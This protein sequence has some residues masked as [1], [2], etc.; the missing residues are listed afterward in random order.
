MI[1]Y[2]QSGLMSKCTAENIDQQSKC[3][4][5]RK[6]T[7]YNRCRFL[8]EAIGNHCDC[9]AAQ[10]YAKNPQE[11]TEEEVLDIEAYI[12][13]PETQRTYERSCLDCQKADKSCPLPAGVGLLKLQQVAGNCG[14]FLLKRTC[15]DCL[16]YK[17]CYSGHDTSKFTAAT[18]QDM[19]ETCS[20]FEDDIPF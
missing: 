13:P 20:Q 10:A 7:D 18:Y 19:A 17:Q 3:H 4:F 14:G 5:A 12:D 6:H 16:K 1:C 11:H 15:T 2:C 9:P 8:V